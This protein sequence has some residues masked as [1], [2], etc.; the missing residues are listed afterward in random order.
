MISNH[1][2]LINA[3][4]EKK[5]C[6]RSDDKPDVFTNVGATKCFRR[7]RSSELVSRGDFVVNEHQG[8][9]LW[10]G[11]AGF[12]ADAFV[13]PIF[14]R[15]EITAERL[16]LICHRLIRLIKQTRLLP[17]SGANAVKQRRPQVMLDESEAERLDRIRN[18]EK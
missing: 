13:K 6:V 8:F 11:P 4:H 3:S 1:S 12:R 5:A 16:T 10:E 17:Q 7:L 9:E 14:R 15:Q 2:G 18:P